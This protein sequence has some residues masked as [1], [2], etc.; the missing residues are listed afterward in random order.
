MKLRILAKGHKVDAT[1]QELAVPDIIEAEATV[2]Q[3]SYMLTNN[4][5]F[6][7]IVAFVEVSLSKLDE[8]VPSNFNNS[9]VSEG[10]IGEE[11]TRQKTWG[12]YTQHIE[13]DTNSILK[14]GYHNANGNRTRP[15][16]SVELQDWIDEYGAGNLLLPEEAR[17]LRDENY[18]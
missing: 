9:S 5:K 7:G 12:E 1:I 15:V 2:A 18:G 4:I 3:I 16:T 17:V 13:N 8:S 6:D 11:S 14:V 10:E